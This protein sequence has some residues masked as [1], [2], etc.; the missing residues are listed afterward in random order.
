MTRMIATDVHSDDIVLPPLKYGY[1][2]TPLLWKEIQQIV[3]V[4]QNF[5]R[6]TRSASQQ[7]E[8]E[9]SKRAIQK[10]WTSML[11]Y[12]LCTKF[13]LP[14]ELNKGLKR[15]VR[16]R[17]DDEAS[18]RTALVR[19]DFPYCFEASVQHWILWKLGGTCTDDDILEAK[20]E[21][22]L[23]SQPP[24]QDLLHWVNPPRLQSLPGI[25]HVHILVLVQRT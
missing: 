14:F 23:K 17:E 16:S 24:I 21:L 9:M 8:Y 3:L 15:A 11:D 10:E 12:V 19:N 20:N 5:D 18:P 13:D 1:C 25:D 4:E 6:L 22:L 7:R 2:E